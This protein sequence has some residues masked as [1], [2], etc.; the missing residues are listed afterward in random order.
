MVEVYIFREKQRFS[1]WTP[2]PE[3]YRVVGAASAAENATS[4]AVKGL[5]IY[6]VT[7]SKMSQLALKK[8]VL[9]FGRT[10]S[11]SCRFAKL[12]ACTRN[13]TQKEKLHVPPSFFVI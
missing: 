7:S 6:N 9:V 2:R 13:L 8:F 11:L 1:D 5:V 3:P 12:N 4:E 10:K